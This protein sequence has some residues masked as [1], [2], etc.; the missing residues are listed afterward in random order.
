MEQQTYTVTLRF[1][2]PAW[3]ERDGID[4]TVCAET[5]REAISRARREAERDGHT[6]GNPGRYWFSAKAEGRS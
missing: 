5:K 2:A 3:D 6:I 4:Y 1:A